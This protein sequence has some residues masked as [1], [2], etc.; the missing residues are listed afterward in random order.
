MLCAKSARDPKEVRYHGAP[1]EAEIIGH[2]SAL[3]QLRSK[4][5]EM[6][7]LLFQT[8]I[9]DRRNWENVGKT[10]KSDTFFL[11]DVQQRHEPYLV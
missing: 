7:E 3:H 11:G 8:Q 5:K 4:D 2:T 9:F 10:D 6:P 1:R